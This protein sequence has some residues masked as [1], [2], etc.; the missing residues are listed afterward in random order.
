MWCYVYWCPINC[1]HT[2]ILFPIVYVFMWPLYII[3]KFKL[4]YY[5]QFYGHC[6]PVPVTKLISNLWRID[7][8]FVT[9]VMANLWPFYIKS[10]RWKISFCDNINFLLWRFQKY[11]VSCHIIDDINATLAAM[12]LL[13]SAPRQMQTPLTGDYDQN[14]GTSVTKSDRH[15]PQTPL[16]VPSGSEAHRKLW[17]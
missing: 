3:C 2:W 1:M 11:D 8:I 5:L 7:V 10:W 12:S 14:I 15:T 9:K 16:T 4:N 13:M 6:D 17:R